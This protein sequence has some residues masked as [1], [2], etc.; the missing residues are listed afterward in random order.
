MRNFELTNSP[1]D[2]IIIKL[3]GAA[4]KRKADELSGSILSKEDLNA[5]KDV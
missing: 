3:S 4:V 5:W 1:K 2:D